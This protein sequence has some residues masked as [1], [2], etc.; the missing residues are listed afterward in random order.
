M[1]DSTDVVKEELASDS[2]SDRGDEMAA[3]SRYCGRQIWPKT[4]DNLP[5]EKPLKIL[6][7]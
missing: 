6:I 7:F 4:I 5:L 1:Q 3:R 2:F